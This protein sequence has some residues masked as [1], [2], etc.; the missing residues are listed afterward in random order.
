MGLV[1]II[2]AALQAKADALG[3][4]LGGGADSYSAP[5][6][7]NGQPPTTHWLCHLAVPSPTFLG[8]LAGA[9]VGQMP[10][11]LGEAGF[12]PADFMA[13]LSA[14]IVENGDPYEIIAGRGLQ[15]VQEGDI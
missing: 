2:P 6:S 10:A 4:A 3:Q 11:A 9:R 8:M 12:P 5:L 7:A 14:L 13:V 15:V 1:L